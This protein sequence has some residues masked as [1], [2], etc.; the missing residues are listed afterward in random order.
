[1]VES[2]ANLMTRSQASMKA[3]E[4]LQTLMSLPGVRGV[5]GALAE[6]PRGRV[7]LRAVNLP[8]GPELP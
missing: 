1:L 8:Q 4:G 2:L 6:A 7:E 3:L 5:V